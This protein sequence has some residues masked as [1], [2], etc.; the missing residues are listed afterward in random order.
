MIKVSGKTAKN[1]EKFKRLVDF[2]WL[3]TQLENVGYP[4]EVFFR[5]NRTAKKFHWLDKESEILT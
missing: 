5:Q 4:N 2:V 1:D 3:M